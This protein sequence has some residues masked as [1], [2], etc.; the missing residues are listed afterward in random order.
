M[1]YATSVDALP[2]IL[3]Q[4]GIAPRSFSKRESVVKMRSTGLTPREEE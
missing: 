1:Q 3:A 4:M 2:L